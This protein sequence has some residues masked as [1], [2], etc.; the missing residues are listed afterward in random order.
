M[1]SG[2]WHPGLGAPSHVES[3]QTS[4]Q[5]H[6]P[7]ISRRILLQEISRL[8]LNQKIPRLIKETAEIRKALKSE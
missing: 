3:Y 5:T 1:G 8:T 6:V 7:C 2:V 4:N